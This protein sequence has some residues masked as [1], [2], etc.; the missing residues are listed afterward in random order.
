MNDLQI[1]HC[2]PDRSSQKWAVILQENHYY[3]FR[4]QMEGVAV[5]TALP[6]DPNRKLYNAGSD[7][8]KETG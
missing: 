2:K 3:P 8:Q 5:N 4:L 7:W 1:V 6:T